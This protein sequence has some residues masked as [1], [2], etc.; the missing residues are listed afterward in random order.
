MKAETQNETFARFIKFE[1]KARGMAVANLIAATCF[2]VSCLVASA[3]N[4]AAS[5]PAGLAAS[6]C[7]MNYFRLSSDY[8]TKLEIIKEIQSLKEASKN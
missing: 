1:S 2:T 8:R 7:F 6:L 5:A 4:P 3:F